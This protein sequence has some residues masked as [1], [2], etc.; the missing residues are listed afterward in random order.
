MAVDVIDEE[1]F[2]VVFEKREGGREARAPGSDLQHPITVRAG[3]IAGETVGKAAEVGVVA[4]APSVSERDRVDRADRLGFR[5]QPVEMVADRDLVGKGDVE[6]RIAAE[7]KRLHEIAECGSRVHL[8]RIEK[9]IDRTKPV[10]GALRLLHGRR[11]R[12]LDAFAD[13]AELKCF[14]RS[15]SLRGERARHRASSPF[16]LASPAGECA[17]SRRWEA[18]QS[19]SPTIDLLGRLSA[20]QSPRHGSSDTGQRLSC[21]SR[22][23]PIDASAETSGNPPSFTATQTF[24]ATRRHRGAKSG[25]VI[26]MR[27]RCRMV[28][29]TG[30]EPVTPSMSTKCSPAELHAQPTSADRP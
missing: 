11:A 3:H 15:E 7:L 20:A 9:A 27:W 17:R 14:R 29:V 18:R 22:S 21:E 12:Q 26:Q 2:D 23:P 30:I 13:Q 6:A 16:P 24:H 28:G 4:K 19:T 8:Q 25:N 1:R 5:R 10:S